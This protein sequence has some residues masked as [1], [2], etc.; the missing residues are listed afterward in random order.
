MRLE[1]I[2][3]EFIQDFGDDKKKVSFPLLKFENGK[4]T[5]LMKDDYIKLRNSLDSQL[6]LWEKS[7]NINNSS[8][9]YK[10]G[11]RNMRKQRSTREIAGNDQID[12]KKTK[13]ISDEESKCECFRYKQR[14]DNI[15]INTSLSMIPTQQYINDVNYQIYGD[16]M[17][18]LNRYSI[19]DKTSKE[20]YKWIPKTYSRTMIKSSDNKFQFTGSIEGVVTKYP[21][22]NQNHTTE[23]AAKIFYQNSYSDHNEI[24]SMV[25]THNDKFQFTG[26]EG[27]YFKKYNAQTGFLIKDYGKILDDI[28]S[29]VINET[30]NDTDIYIGGAGLDSNTNI[31][32]VLFSFNEDKIIKTFDYVSTNSI[33]CMIL[34]N[35]GQ[36]QLISYDIGYLKLLFVRSQKVGKNFGKI[37]NNSIT[38]M[39]ST[40][41][42]NFLFTGDKSG[43]IKMISLKNHNIFKHFGKVF[44]SEI[45]S[46]TI[47]PNNQFL[48]CTDKNEG[49]LKQW[50]IPFPEFKVNLGKI[51]S[52]ISSLCCI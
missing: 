43:Y 44:Q 40:S 48:F 29:L 11:K 26:S 7:E 22:S 4:Y 27:G 20:I 33:Y 51:N 16:V 19:E 24:W 46:M 8:L 9:G 31:N 1:N 30:K 21:I 14:G 32:L 49:N 6:L 42:D 41:D 52:K 12:L 2:Q 25:T 23:Y 36:N 34:I 45:W 39:V 10:L 18:R 3:E 50:F 47:S 17:G 5:L 13:L 38:N 15:N 28:S 35:N 37:C